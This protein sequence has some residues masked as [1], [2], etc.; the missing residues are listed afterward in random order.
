M[1]NMAPAIAILR[2]FSRRGIAAVA[3][4]SRRENAAMLRDEAGVPVFT[5]EPSLKDIPAS[6]SLAR[7]L[8]NGFDDQTAGLAAHAV[9]QGLLRAIAWHTASFVIHSIGANRAMER[10]TSRYLIASLLTVYEGTPLAA[11][12]GRWAVGHGM[13]WVGAFPILVGD[14]PDGHHFPAQHHLVYGEQLRDLAVRDGQPAE[15]VHVVGSPNYDRFLGRNQTQDRALIANSFPQGLGRKL[16]VV[17]TEAFS[18]PFVELGPVLNS[19]NAIEG[20]FVVL[21]VHPSDDEEMFARFAAT[22]PFTYRIAVTKEFDL[23]AL[24]HCADLLV[25]IVSNVIVS[26]AVLGT[27]TLVCDFSGKSKVIDF[28]REGL[29]EGCYDPALIRQTVEGLLFDQKTREAC[30][31][32][33]ARGVRRFN[34]PND[35]QSAQRIV[36]FLVAVASPQPSAA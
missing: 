15:H 13:P 7:K 8:R 19:V 2:E 12:T 23:G 25:C 20:A 31:A 21:K 30:I 11:T 3:V 6:I 34:G 22:L 16:V 18:D 32:R 33:L 5:S 10:L 4:T 36:D 29:A 24:L 26:A 1:V 14:R 9:E 35:G 28:V 27:P 17:A